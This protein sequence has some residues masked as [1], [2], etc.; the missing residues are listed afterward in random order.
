MIVNYISIKFVTVVGNLIAALGSAVVASASLFA[1]GNVVEA[2]VAA[3]TV[4]GLVLT[5]VWRSIRVVTVAAKRA[6]E[7]NQLTISRLEEEVELLRRDNHRLR[8]NGP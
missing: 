7:L 6:D 3:G 1:G 4:G 2:A 8:G 5:I